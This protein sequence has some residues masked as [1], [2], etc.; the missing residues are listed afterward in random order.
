MKK[1][2]KKKAFLAVALYQP[3]GNGISAHRAGGLT[4]HLL[5]DGRSRH[6]AVSFW[7]LLVVLANRATYLAALL[8]SLFVR[9]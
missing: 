3:K 1:T 7:Q 6:Y 4:F 2:R 8:P 9:L 5:C